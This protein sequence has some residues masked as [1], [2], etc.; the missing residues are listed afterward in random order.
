MGSVLEN[1]NILCESHIHNNIIYKSYIFSWSNPDNLTPNLI[2]VNL[3]H[4]LNVLDI[5]PLDIFITNLKFS[6]KKNQGD[7]ISVILRNARAV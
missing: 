5:K 7:G 2:S 4:L 1:G 6:Q 3:E